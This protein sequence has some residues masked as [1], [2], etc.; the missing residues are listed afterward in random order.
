MIKRYGALVACSI[1]SGHQVFERWAKAID[2]DDERL[3]GNYSMM[4]YRQPTKCRFHCRC[5]F[6]QR[7][8]ERDFLT[9]AMTVGKVDEG[10]R[11]RRINTLLVQ[12]TI[13]WK[14]EPRRGLAISFFRRCG[15][16]AWDTT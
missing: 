3:S 4:R 8:Q 13:E 9:V 6:V 5:E 1:A 12:L 7:F 2:Y 15:L 14:R 11:G 10:G 16:G